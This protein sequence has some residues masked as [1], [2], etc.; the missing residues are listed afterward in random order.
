MSLASLR[1]LA[2]YYGIEDLRVLYGIEGEPRSLVR[3]SERS[4][5]VWPSGV[6]FEDLT[7][8]NR[9]L[10]GSLLKLPPHSDSGG[11]YAH[12]GEEFVYVLTGSLFVD[13]KSEGVVRLE[14]DDTLYFQSTMPHR[15]WSEDEA[16]SAVWVN[17]QPPQPPKP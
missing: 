6:V 4:A 2:S 15:F 8:P 3:G 10:N 9:L 5:M 14:P 13:V 11:Y 16:V 7:G 1:L 12:G 17:M